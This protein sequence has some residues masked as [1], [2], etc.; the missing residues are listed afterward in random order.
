MSVTMRT[1]TQVVSDLEKVDQVL[2]EAQTKRALLMKELEEM[3][4]FTSDA[5]ARLKP[6]DNVSYLPTKWGDY[7]GLGRPLAAGEF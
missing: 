5:V 4:A 2:A 1:A 6:V 7:P 3:S